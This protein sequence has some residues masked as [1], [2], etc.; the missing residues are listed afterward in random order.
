[1]HIEF[2]PKGPAGITLCSAGQSVGCPEPASSGGPGAH[3]RDMEA[4]HP[5]TLRLCGR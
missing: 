5:Y 3:G 1:M 4:G 2:G